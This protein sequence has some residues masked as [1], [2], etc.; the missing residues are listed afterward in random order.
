MHPSPVCDNLKK[1]DAFNDAI[2]LGI[3]I[4]KAL[5]LCHRNSIIYRDVKPENIFLTSWGGYK[6]GDFSAATALLGPGGAPRIGTL[7]Y[8]APE[9]YT[10]RPY[11]A[12]IDTYALGLTMYELLS[13]H[14]ET[15]YTTRHRE[16][17]ARMNGAPLEKPA[18][19]D[20][21][22]FAIIETACAYDPEDRFASAA[23][24]RMSLEKLRNDLCGRDKSGRLRGISQTET[25]AE[26]KAETQA[27]P[28]SGASSSGKSFFDRLRKRRGCDTVSVSVLRIQL[29]RARSR[30]N[31]ARP[32]T[33][34]VQLIQLIRKC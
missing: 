20:A 15:T 1:Q 10:L 5:D 28:Q 11:S 22:L 12:N 26:L 32:S 4:C 2:A 30:A 34:T 29:A 16:I 3:D 13:A 31:F 9:I 14:M 8:M 19:V 33:I 17:F 18:G 25:Q 21:K 7:K 27:G 23:D 6:L 24:M